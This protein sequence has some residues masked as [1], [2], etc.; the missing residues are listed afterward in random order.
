[1][2]ALK[3]AIGEDKDEAIPD[4]E[5]KNEAVPTQDPNAQTLDVIDSTNFD[6]FRG[7]IVSFD[8]SSIDLAPSD[9]VDGAQQEFS[10]DGTVASISE[11]V[12]E[13]NVSL[14]STLDSQALS[15]DRRGAKFRDRMAKMKASVKNNVKT[16]NENVKNLKAENRV[17]RRQRL[18]SSSGRMTNSTTAMK[19]K[20]VKAHEETPPSK[21]PVNIEP[22]QELHLMPGLWT[23]HTK[24]E[25]AI[26]NTNLQEQ[27]NENFEENFLRL[28]ITLCRS[29]ITEAKNEP[30]KT[31]LQK[32]IS[33]MIDFHM[34]IS[35][36]LTSIQQNPKA[37]SLELLEQ[38]GENEE[39]F[40]HVINSGKI[41]LGLLR[42]H[43]ATPEHPKYFEHTGENVVAHCLAT[44]RGIIH[45]F[46]A[47][48]LE[49]IR[50]CDISVY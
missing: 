11:D 44:H 22:N 34:K 41:L 27:Q 21:E 2:K 14:A 5:S 39:L 42:L 19:L 32:T 46:P 7:T 16:M 4:E 45:H 9:S 12:L 15:S 40:A 17:P 37:A 24:I 13:D 1:M 36:I 48:F 29:A 20:Q 26:R 25:V 47:N 43:E 33:Q 28:D 30:S 8:D 18:G 35:S 6:D 38:L 49:S 31:Q 23:C 10:R 3:A 50:F